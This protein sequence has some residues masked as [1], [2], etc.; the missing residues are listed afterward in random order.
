MQLCGVHYMQLK[1]LY[2]WLLAVRLPSPIGILCLC[3]SL[4]LEEHRNLCSAPQT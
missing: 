1:K 3:W 2:A 4:G